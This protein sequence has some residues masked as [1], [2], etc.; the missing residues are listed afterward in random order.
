MP[1]RST[2][3]LS[4]ALFQVHYRAP[5]NIRGSGKERGHGCELRQCPKCG[6][7]LTSGKHHVGCSTANKATP[8][9][10]AKRARNVRVIQQQHR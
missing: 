2:K 5:P 9:K 10:P 4:R 1:C 3:L 8:R 7:E 6:K